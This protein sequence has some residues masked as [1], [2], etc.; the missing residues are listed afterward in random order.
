MLSDIDDL[1][2]AGFACD[3]ASAHCGRP[4][5]ITLHGPPGQLSGPSDP[6]GQQKTG[7]ARRRP[8]QPAKLKMLVYLGGRFFFCL[9][10]KFRPGRPLF[11][12]GTWTWQGSWQGRRTSEK[13]N[14]RGGGKASLLNCSAAS[15]CF[16]CFLAEAAR[17]PA[18]GRS[19]GRM[20]ARR[21][22]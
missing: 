2:W 6:S 15:R 11:Y 1:P 3:A 12:D 9:L 18:Q 19:G 10:D 16:P 8:G 20:P 14:A 5:G 4:T 13:P 7:R 22:V 17:G 21:S